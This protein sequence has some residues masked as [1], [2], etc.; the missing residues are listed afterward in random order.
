MAQVVEYL[1]LSSNLR[2]ALP[3]PKY[4]L[5]ERGNKETNENHIQILLISFFITSDTEEK[6][7]YIFL[8][9]LKLYIG[10]INPLYHCLNN[11]VIP[12]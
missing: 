8:S 12:F 6:K 1:P 10:F 3:T 7:R 9:S 2:T 11:C 4:Q 5:F